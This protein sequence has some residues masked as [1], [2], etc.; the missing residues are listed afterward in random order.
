M[1]REIVWTS[2]F[3]KD[4]KLAQK[5][6]RNTKLLDDLIRTLAAGKALTPKFNDHSLSGRW[7]GHRECHISPNWL[8]I[9]RL[10]GNDL[11]LILART[12]SHDDLF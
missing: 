4:Y 9:Y 6:G 5:R 11:I 7:N 12:G 2:Q 3:K 1:K 10:E 8:L